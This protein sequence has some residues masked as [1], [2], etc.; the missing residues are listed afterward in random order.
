VLSSQR[1]RLLDAI[2]DVVA[3]KGYGR[4]TV[5]DVVSAAGVSRKTFYEHFA[6]KEECFLAAYEAGVDLLVARLEEAEAS[7]D[8]WPDR[9]RAGVRAYLDTLRFEPAFARTFLLEIQAAGP[10]ALELRARVH[11]RFRARLADLHR[12]FGV[13]A[14][15]DREQPPEALLLALVGGIDEVCTE[16]VRAGRTAHLGELEST[17]VFLH[18]ALFGAPVGAGGAVT[19]AG[20]GR[21]DTPRAAGGADSLGEAGEA[22]AR[23]AVDEP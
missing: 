8:A 2:A 15:G 12:R 13:E 16:W 18:L 19:P 1:G 9:V 22:D 11:R 14:G 10:R 17:L 21:T 3:E 23:A 6:G 5:A 20:V 4:T 7:H